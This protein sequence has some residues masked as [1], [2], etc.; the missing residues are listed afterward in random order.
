[1]IYAYL[2]KDETTGERLESGAADI[3][4]I[5]QR[6]WSWRPSLDESKNPH[7][8]RVNIDS[9]PSDGKPGIMV[10]RWFHLPED[11]IAEFWEP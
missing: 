6:L 3:D 4:K 7:D 11:V 5:R 9:Y 1:M 8:L 2:I 10:L